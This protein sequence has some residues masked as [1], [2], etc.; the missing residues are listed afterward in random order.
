MKIHFPQTAAWLERNRFELIDTI[1]G[2]GVIQV[3]YGKGNLVLDFTTDA[4]AMPGSKR[5]WI[6]LG[7]PPRTHGFPESSDEEAV[8]WLEQEFTK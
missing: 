1:H 3:T 2:L 5:S 7:D 6:R 4:L 8:A